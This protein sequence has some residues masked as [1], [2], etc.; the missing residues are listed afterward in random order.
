VKPG[1]EADGVT[2]IRQVATEGLIASLRDHFDML[3]LGRPGARGFA[4]PAIVSDFMSDPGPLG[5]LANSLLDHRM[6]PVRVL[7][8]D[9]TADSNWAVP[10]H[11]DRAIAV[12]QR[13]D[14]TGFGPWSVKDGVVHVEP[15]VSLLEGMLTLR[16]FVDDCDQDNG[17]LQVACGS[18]CHGRVPAAEVNR[19]AAGSDIF[20]G[21]G[22]AADVL[23]MRLLAIHSSRRAVRPGHRRVLH[24]D[25]AST[26]LPPPLA[27][28]T[29]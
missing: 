8:F 1:F 10:W 21:A 22:H 26:D 5:A 29:L 28:A 17:P 23:A 19:I 15:P 3:D 4:V 25:Y 18:H 13:H 24:V 16:L 11:Q 27:W 7:F 2:I 9:K 12:K 6:K 14:V 20:V